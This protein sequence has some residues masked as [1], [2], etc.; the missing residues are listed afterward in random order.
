MGFFKTAAE[1]FEQGN[2][3]IKMKEYSKARAAFE[4]AISKKTKEYEVAQVMITLLNLQENNKASTYASTA[5]FLQQKG[6]LEVTFGFSAIKCSNLAI[7]CMAKAAELNALE[8]PS[9]NSQELKARAEALFTAAIKYQSEIGMNTLIIPEV[10][11]TVKITGIHKASYLMATGNEDMAESVAMEDPKRAAEYLLTALNYRRQLDDIN[12]EG[13][14][15]E[16]IKL[17]SKS[18]ACWI[19]GREATGETIHFVSMPTEVTSFQSKSKS[20]SPLPSINNNASIYVCKA[21]YL[22]ISKRADAI[23]KQHLEIAITEMRNMEARLNEK[24]NAINEK[25]NVVNEK[26]N[27]TNAWINARIR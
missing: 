16:K 17:Y 19:C 8:M 15:Q 7:E 11:T 22:A 21:C 1:E 26:A 25:I 6:E 12:A 20:T 23:S 18:A 4:K 5:A 3:Y 13:K 9:N 2:K 24:I 14:I 10:Y 27:A